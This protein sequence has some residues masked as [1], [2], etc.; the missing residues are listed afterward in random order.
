M[1][2]IKKYLEDYHAGK[3][4]MGLGINIPTIDSHL[5]FKEAQFTMINGHDNVGKTVWILW[6]FLCL[7]TIHNKKFIV[8]S[9]ENKEGALMRTLIQFASGVYFKDL[10]LGKVYDWYTRLSE[11]FEFVDT[12]KLY[13]SKNLLDIFAKSK[14]DAAL[15]DPYTGIDR[16][17][18]HA[19][20]YQFLNEARHFCNSVGM[21]LYVNTHP[22]T[23]AAR[24]LHTKDSC[25]GDDSLIGYPKP[26]L[27]SQSEGGQPFANR[28]DD[29]I[30]IHRYVGHPIY[31][32]ETMIFTRKVKDTDTGGMV[33][34]INEGVT[35][36]YNKGL[37]F[38]CDGINPLSKTITDDY[39][40]E[41]MQI[42][43][44]FE[45]G[46]DLDLPF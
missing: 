33:M 5:R 25:G 18:T 45:D 40:F 16:D 21:G 38:I 43:S 6:Y 35:F 26:P 28:P 17:F 37:G 10:E 19:S 8:Y 7:A 4:K 29:F 24:S 23:E 11:H 13:T 1:S 9:A 12:T 42:N 15:I 39:A 14:A 44:N 22:N 2:D 41:K 46:D 30:T 31:N 32:Y 3:I 20:N 27:K 34:P 36:Q